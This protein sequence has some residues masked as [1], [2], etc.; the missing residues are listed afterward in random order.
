MCKVAGYA[1]DLEHT[2][3]LVASLHIPNKNNLPVHKLEWPINDYLAKRGVENVKAGAIFAPGRVPRQDP[4]L[5]QFKIEDSMLFITRHEWVAKNEWKDGP[6]IIEE[7]ESDREVKKWLIEQGG[8][9]D[10]QIR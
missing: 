4:E 3:Q 7:N 1:V 5:A 8:L 9:E 10:S 6:V 2:V